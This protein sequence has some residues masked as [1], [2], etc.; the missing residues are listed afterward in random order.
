MGDLS[1]DVGFQ[2]GESGGFYT[3]GC[4]GNAEW[5]GVGNSC[6]NVYL[7]AHRLF[8]IVVDGLAR[9]RF[10]ILSCPTVPER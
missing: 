9:L 7:Q 4:C 3:E 2:R 6:E 10:G 1:H 8:D 5:Q